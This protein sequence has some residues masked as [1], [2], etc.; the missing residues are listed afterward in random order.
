VESTW[1]PGR[2]V[3]VAGA[4]LVVGWLLVGWGRLGGGRLVEG[5]VRAEVE[6][7][8]REE[9]GAG[10]PV[11][12]GLA[13]AVEDGAGEGRLGD[14]GGRQVTAPAE[15]FLTGRV[16]GSG[17]PGPEQRAQLEETI[18]AYSPPPRW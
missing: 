9:P 7:R 3:D 8:D 15:G 4:L 5:G 17:R 6:D 10:E 16:T 2:V 1:S 13:A 14:D 12:A 18:V 11:E